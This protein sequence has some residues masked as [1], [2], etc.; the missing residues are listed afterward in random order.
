MAV[1]Q[2]TN[3]FVFLRKCSFSGFVN[4]VKN[5]LNGRKALADWMNGKHALNLLTLE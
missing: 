1:E 4:S 5:H 3:R 2:S